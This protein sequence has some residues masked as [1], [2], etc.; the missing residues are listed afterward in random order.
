MCL[1]F[2]SIHN[3]LRQRPNGVCYPVSDSDIVIAFFHELKLVLARLINPAKP[4]LPG[5]IQCSQGRSTSV[6]ASDPTITQRNVMPQLCSPRFRTA[7]AASP[8]DMTRLPSSKAL[9]EK[10]CVGAKLGCGKYAEVF[11]CQSRS[12]RQAFAIKCSKKVKHWENEIIA[13]KTLSHECIIRMEEAFDGSRAVYIVMELLSGGNLYH[14]VTRHIYYTETVASQL[15]GNLLSAVAYMHEHGVV[16]RDLKPENILLQ[17]APPD[18]HT[19]PKNTRHPMTNIKI[20]DFGL[21]GIAHE[22]QG[23]TRVCG[24]PYYIAPEVLECA[25]DRKGLTYGPA[26]D[27]WS[28]GVLAYVILVGVPPFQAPEVSDVLAAVLKGKWSFPSSVPLSAA[29]RDFIRRLLVPDPKRRLTARQALRHPWIE[30]ASER[31]T[32]PLPVV[33]AS[34]DTFRQSIEVGGK[35]DELSRSWV[36]I[37]QA[38]VAA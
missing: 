4:G 18:C 19:N 9:L 22:E 11:H 15:L 5:H 33:Q 32:Y 25:R 12:T 14:F 31:S 10:Y 30:D 35:N 27:L 20:T 36:F 13:L 2:A 17:Q 37:D 16:H 23:L 34:V 7:K 29:A 3:R 1:Q 38:M 24:T 8:D 26:C 6:L 28:L 21:A